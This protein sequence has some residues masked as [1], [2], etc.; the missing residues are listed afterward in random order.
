MVAQLT[1]NIK[2]EITQVSN[3]QNKLEAAISVERQRFIEEMQALVRQAQEDY[4]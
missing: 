1:K 2:N 4:E 3:D